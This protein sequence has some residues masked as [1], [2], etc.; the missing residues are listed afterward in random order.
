MPSMPVRWLQE[1]AFILSLAAQVEFSF[2]GPYIHPPYSIMAAQKNARAPGIRL[3]DLNF[4]ARPSACI[5]GV[6][7]FSVPQGTRI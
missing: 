1:M 5:L 2:G 4:W 7:N 6:E 3:R